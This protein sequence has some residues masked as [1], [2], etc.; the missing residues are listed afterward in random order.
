MSVMPTFLGGGQ[1]FG[2]R[3]D[4]S[5]EYIITIICSWPFG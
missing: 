5:I 2:V 1:L 4:V 3:K